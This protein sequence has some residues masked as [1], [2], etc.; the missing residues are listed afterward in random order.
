MNIGKTIYAARS[1]KWIPHADMV[2]PRLG[3]LY[4]TV[5]SVYSN[6]RDNTYH[7]KKLFKA[8]NVRFPIYPRNTVFISKSS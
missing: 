4:L 5:I 3:I 7:K 2:R 8:T 6:Y 1:M